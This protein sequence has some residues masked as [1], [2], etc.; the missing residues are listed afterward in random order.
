MLVHGLPRGSDTIFLLN[1]LSGT[2]AQQQEQN[3]EVIRM[4]SRTAP[5]QNS[6]PSTDRNQLPE[7]L[8]I[9]M[10]ARLMPCAMDSY[11]READ[12]VHHQLTFTFKLSGSPAECKIEEVLTQ[13]R[14]KS[15]EDAEQLP[16][17][18]ME[19]QDI[20]KPSHTGRRDGHQHIRETAA[21]AAMPRYGQTQEEAA[22]ENSSPTIKFS[23]TP[24]QALLS[25][26][27][28]TGQAA[29]HKQGESK[30]WVL[31]FQWQMSLGSHH[32]SQA[33]EPSDRRP[34]RLRW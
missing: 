28:C 23:P 15:S 31:A 13:A 7:V 32:T 16:N 14:K 9:F 20:Q 6:L 33:E 3:R 19:L 11:K 5:F 8:G 2:K 26:P 25:V 22:L 30:H 27:R 1:L 4:Q 17:W 12:Q 10:R 29:Q 34:R 21:A 24:G 18:V